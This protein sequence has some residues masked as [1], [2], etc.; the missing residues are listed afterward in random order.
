MVE[1]NVANYTDDTTLYVCKK[2]SDV[3]RKLEPESSILF[4]GYHDNYLKVNSGKSH[5]MWTA[6]NKLKINVKSSLI[7]NEKIVKLLWVAVANNL[8]F[9]PALDFVCKT[10]SQKLLARVSKFI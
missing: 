8:F 5:I 4:E 2:L 7:S 1:S 9:K 10:G 3:Q 6:D